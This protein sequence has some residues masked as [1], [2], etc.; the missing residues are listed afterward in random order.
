[1]PYIVEVD[2]NRTELAERYWEELGWKSQHWQKG[3][4]LSP[5]F[6]IHMSTLETLFATCFNSFTCGFLFISFLSSQLSPLLYPFIISCYL[7]L[8]PNLFLFLSF[9]IWS[10]TVGLNSLMLAVKWFW[11]AA[12]KGSLSAKYIQKLSNGFGT[13]QIS[14]NIL[15]ICYTI[16]DSWIFGKFS[17][18]NVKLRTVAL[19]WF[20]SSMHGEDM[21]SNN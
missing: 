6:Q 13:K 16:S 19:T 5:E 15:H 1:M 17:N 2:G 4:R 3:R 10:L 21:P 8:L 12:Q 18:F 9:P 7:V 11:N 14:N 20:Y